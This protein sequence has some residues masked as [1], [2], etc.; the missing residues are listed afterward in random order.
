MKK[1]IKVKTNG[2]LMMTPIFL[3]YCIFLEEK[4][5]FVFFVQ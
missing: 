3:F 5:K 1:G 2:G 4:G